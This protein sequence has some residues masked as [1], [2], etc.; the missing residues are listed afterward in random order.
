MVFVEICVDNEKVGQP[1]LH[2]LQVNPSRCV[3]KD[4]IRVFKVRSER[5]SVIKGGHFEPNV[6][7]RGRHLEWRAA[8][9]NSQVGNT[10]SG[11]RL[12]NFLV[13]ENADQLVKSR[14]PD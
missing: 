7:C 8:M 13:A 6:N 1:E 10:D 3:A 12:K 14:G 4:Y 9:L 5:W 11:Q 2:G